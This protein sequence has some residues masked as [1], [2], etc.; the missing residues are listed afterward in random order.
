MMFTQKINH[1]KNNFGNITLKHILIKDQKYIGLKFYPNKGIQ[2]IIQKHNN[3]SWNEEFSMYITN[4]IKENFNA[5]FSHFKGVAWINGTHFFEGKKVLKMNDTINLDTYRKRPP[6]TH[7]VAPEEYLAKLE[8]KRY[9][10]NTARTYI[11][12]F[13]KFI[14]T[15]PEKPLLE[16]NENDIQEYLNINARKGVSTSLL[17]QIVNSIK[18]YYEVVEQM[19]NR[20]YSIDRPIKMETL[21]KVLSP[22]TVKKILLMTRNIKHKCI[23]SLLYSAGLRRQ[24]LLNLKIS[25][26]DSKRMVIFISQGKGHKDRNT[27]LSPSVLNDLRLYFKE[28]KPKTY[29]FEGPNGSQYS[30]TSVAKI[31]DAARIRAGVR[32]KVTPHMLRHSF[33]T[34]LLENGTDLRYIQTLL[35]HSS[36][37]TT[38]IYTK[39]SFSSIQNIKSPIDSLN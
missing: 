39:V 24:E 3:Y 8:Y 33:A 36:T 37:K 4:N 25:D 19:P 6:R 9:A 2:A 7:R 16:I 21:P 31:L 29:L 17:N 23:L 1:M 12:C 38:E 22:E 26:I 11:S 14:N 30:A 34:H 20:F 28:C 15:F 27:I 13:E 35:G 18:F 32:E 5:I 10:M